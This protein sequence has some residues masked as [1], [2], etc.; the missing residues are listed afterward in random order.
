MSFPVFLGYQVPCTCPVQEA[1]M[2]HC[3]VANFH[4]MRHG[5]SREVLW[6]RERNRN[7]RETSS[8]KSPCRC[9]HLAGLYWPGIGMLSKLENPI[10]T[11]WN[12]F[13][14]GKTFEASQSLDLQQVDGK[15]QVADSVWRN[16]NCAAEH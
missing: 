9:S 6:S 13:P 14:K 11:H 5:T 16:F 10:M 7:R 4:W 1:Y 8:Q 12:R 15:Q 3:E 2:F